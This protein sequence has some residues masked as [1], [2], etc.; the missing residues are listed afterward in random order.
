[1][2]APSSTRFAGGGESDHKAGR[3]NILLLGADAGLAHLAGVP[4]LTKLNVYI[5]SQVTDAGLAHLKDMRQL[6]SLNLQGCEQ[7]TDAGLAALRAALPLTN[8][9]T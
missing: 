2:P 9:S 1:M 7:V 3:F 6:T 8:V 5:G 4:Q